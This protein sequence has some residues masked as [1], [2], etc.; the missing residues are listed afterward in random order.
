MSLPALLRACIMATGSG[1][2]AP[3]GAMPG[4]ITA[5]MPGAMCGIGMCMA[6][7]I[8]CPW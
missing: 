6:I 2:A 7:G 4:A 3:I 1:G 5:G 8:G